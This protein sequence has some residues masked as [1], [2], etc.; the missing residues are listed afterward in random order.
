MLTP[1]PLVFG[2]L[3]GLISL[4][5]PLLGLGLIY[6]AFKV[7]RRHVRVLR[8]RDQGRTVVTEELPASAPREWR[9]R[10]REPAF[11]VPLLTGLCLIAFTFAGRH[12]VQYAFP[13][14]PNEPVT[15]RG[16]PSDLTR[17]DG[18]NIHVETFGPATAP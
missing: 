5:V 1:I 9:Y 3:L 2:L 18:T 7:S 6:I 13:A 15:L 17:P 4:T 8:K 10:L 11:S 12:L 16:T 14:G